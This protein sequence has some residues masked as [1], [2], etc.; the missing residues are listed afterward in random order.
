MLADPVKLLV[1]RVLMELDVDK[2]KR[3]K[4][5]Y[6]LFTRPPRKRAETRK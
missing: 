5:K 2:A 4:R 1:K 3:G 6:V